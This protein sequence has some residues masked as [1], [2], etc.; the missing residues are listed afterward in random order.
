[1]SNW[2]K[3]KEHGGIIAIV[4]GLIAVIGMHR[5]DTNMLLTEMSGMRKDIT[6]VMV[7]IENHE[8][9]INYL[10]EGRK[11]IMAPAE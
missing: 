2:N 8:C 11:P 4:A 1:M 9:H 7:R 3:I 6:A 5:S 10:M